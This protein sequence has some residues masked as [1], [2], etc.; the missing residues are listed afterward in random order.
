V[1][2]LI[3][4]K[5][6]KIQTPRFPAKPITPRSQLR[7]FVRQGDRAHEQRKANLTRLRQQKLVGLYG[8]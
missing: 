7:S 2:G 1:Y 8:E 5:N 3:L 6:V 4:L